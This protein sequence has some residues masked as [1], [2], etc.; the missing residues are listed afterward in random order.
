[1]KVSGYVALSETYL[2]VD[3]FVNGTRWG[4][5]STNKMIYM[6]WRGRLQYGLYSNLLLK[7]QHRTE[8]LGV[9]GHHSEPQG[10]L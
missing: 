10:S 3:F 4:T 5:S 7:V 2:C 6:I 9:C 1:M 8:D